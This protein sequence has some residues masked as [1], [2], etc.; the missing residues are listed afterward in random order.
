MSGDNVAVSKDGP[1]CRECRNTAQ[2][3]KRDK[4]RGRPARPMKKSWLA[5]LSVEQVKDMAKKWDAA[6]QQHDS[7]CATKESWKEKT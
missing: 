6:I 7:E 5:A 4:K 3:E 2:Q 1:V